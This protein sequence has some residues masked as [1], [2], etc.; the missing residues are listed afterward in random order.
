MYRQLLK[1][2]DEIFD[3]DFFSEKVMRE[4]TATYLTSEAQ[5]AEDIILY[6]LLSHIENGSYV[7]VGCADPNRNSVTRLFYMKGWRG[8]N[9]DPRPEVMALY[10]KERPEDINLCIAVSDKTGHLPFWINGELS[11]F[12]ES[13]VERLGKDN[14]TPATV[15]VSTLNNLLDA[16]CRKPIHFLKIDVEA[17]EAEVLGGLDLK[18]YRPY[19]LAVESTLP[20]TTTPSYESWESVLFKNDYQFFMQYSINRFYIAKEKAD[21]IT[22]NFHKNLITPFIYRKHMRQLMRIYRALRKFHNA[23]T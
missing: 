11:T 19:V 4:I 10:P 18:K 21:E 13:T 23:E 6:K 3:P 9:I 14:F 17:H 7:D 15:E 16:Y 2:M 8:L 5:R 12:D 1:D 20:M 22:G